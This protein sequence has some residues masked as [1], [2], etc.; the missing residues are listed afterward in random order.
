MLAW[1]QTVIK[2]IQAHIYRSEQPARTACL[3]PFPESLLGL[4]ASF[5]RRALW[6]SQA[7]TSS[8]AMPGSVAEW[9]AVATIYRSTIIVTSS[10]Y[11]VSP[12]YL[13]SVR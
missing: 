10:Q 3:K 5:C 11:Q 7:V 2:F 12:A 9:P 8:E 4:Q 13:C 6:S 1:I